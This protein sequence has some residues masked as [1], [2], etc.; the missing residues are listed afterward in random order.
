VEQAISTRP[1]AQLTERG[2]A[3]R[4]RAMAL[5]ALERYDLDVHHLRLMTNHLNGLFRVDATGGTYAL[6]IS[7]PTWRDDSELRSELSWLQALAAA[8]DIGAPSPRPNRDDA[9]ITMVAADG[10]PEPRRCVLFTW[11]PG[12][13]L[14]ERLTERN[15]E[16]LGELSARLHAHAA[17]FT[18][19]DGFTTRRLDRLFPRD[20]QV[21]LFAR[22]H[23]HLFTRDGRRILERA[24]E[25]AQAALDHRYAGPRGPRVIH[26]DLHHQN[27]KVARGRLRPVDFED[28]IWG[29]PAQDIA[30]TFYD[31]RYFT[32]PAVHD[33]DLLCAWFR[34]GYERLA[35]WPEQYPGQIET[36]LVARRIWV[37]NWCLQNLD[38]AR[39][40]AALPRE[41]ERLRQFLAVTLDVPASARLRYNRPITASETI[42][43]TGRDDR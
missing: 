18:P 6:R 43:T 21:V 3:R 11:V 41:I 25:R 13:L 28:V 10:V 34:H 22:A 20:E 27:V 14:A 40:A 30:L 16:R 36:F 32:D 7:E 12:V 15:V 23:Q 35:P 5:A 24:M 9:L 42:D 33:Y 19:P 2:Q 26:G 39:N 31:F 1:F 38:E 29:Y 8:T 17:K 4:L 37:I